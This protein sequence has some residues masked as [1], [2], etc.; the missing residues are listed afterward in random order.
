[1][2]EILMLCKLITQEPIAHLLISQIGL[3]NFKAFG[4]V[5][6]NIKPITIFVGPN[7]TGKSSILEAI[8]LMSDSVGS[9]L[10]IDGNLVN[11]PNIETI[12]HRGDKSLPLIFQ[13]GIDLVDEESSRVL[14][15]TAKAGSGLG[16]KAKKAT[17][18]YVL[19]FEDGG[20]QEEQTIH[21]GNTLL[22]GAYRSHKLEKLEHA[23]KTVYRDERPSLADPNHVQ[24]FL[25]PNS[26]RMHELTG[27][28]SQYFNELINVIIN[29]FIRR[30]QDKVRFLVSTRGKIEH[31]SSATTDSEWVGREGY[32]PAITNHDRRNYS[33]YC[34]SYTGVVILSR[35]SIQV[36]ISR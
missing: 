17:Y 35:A 36:R 10:N 26:L 2:I 11:Y 14:D 8:C 19:S 21:L 3:R 16:L 4:E 33:I 32:L 34:P 9:N 31:V 24:S 27:S 29:F 1:M 6:A 5:S 20:L 7:G 25:N 15:L 23:L 22:I 28:K 13:L 12:F 18:R 30:L